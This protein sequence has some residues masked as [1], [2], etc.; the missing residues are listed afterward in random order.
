MQTQRLPVKLTEEEIKLRG[1]QLAGLEDKYEE[2]QALGKQEAKLRKDELEGLRA[3]ILRLTKQINSGKE[4][5]DV[6][7]E[8]RK[9]WETEEVLTFRCDNYEI[10]DR[11]PMTPNE[12]QRGLFSREEEERQ[13][14]DSVETVTLS[15]SARTVTLTGEQFE[16][17]AETRARIA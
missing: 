8:E 7:T 6:Q 16:Q 12:L 4:Q 11:R 17:A 2:V 10:V 13:P 1:Q 9:E 14:F 15:S 5:R 3:E